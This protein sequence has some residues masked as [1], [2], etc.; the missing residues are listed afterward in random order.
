M[1]CVKVVLALITPNCALSESDLDC[2]DF[3][4]DDDDNDDDTEQFSLVRRSRVLAA[5]MIC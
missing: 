5:M 1:T 2:V 3:D 4:D